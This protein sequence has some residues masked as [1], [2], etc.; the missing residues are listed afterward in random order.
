MCKLLPSRSFEKIKSIKGWR[1][2][3]DRVLW[4]IA[5]LVLW[6]CC[7]KKNVL[8]TIKGIKDLEEKSRNGVIEVILN[9]WFSVDR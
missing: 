1:K 8:I 9:P 5:S 2:F 6:K 3:N 7:N 4:K